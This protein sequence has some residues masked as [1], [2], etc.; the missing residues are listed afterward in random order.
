MWL[1]MLLAVVV[2]VLVYAFFLRDILRES[3]W[4][5]WFYRWIE[6]IEAK[7]WQKSRT[8]LVARLVWVPSALITVHDFLLPALGLINW[9]PIS[10]RLLLDVGIPTDFHAAAMAA[11]TALIGKVFLELRKVTTE[12]LETKE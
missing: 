9:N 7:L 11:F 4:F 3:A 5:G 6:P 8:V 1:W 12:P 2:L 10:T